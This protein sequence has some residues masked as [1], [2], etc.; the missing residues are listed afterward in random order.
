MSH[1]AQTACGK[2]LITALVF[3]LAP[4]VVV[5]VVKAL[6]N[7]RAVSVPIYMVSKDKFLPEHAQAVDG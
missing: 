1:S 4:V 2:T 6:C 3:H 7:Y 5:V